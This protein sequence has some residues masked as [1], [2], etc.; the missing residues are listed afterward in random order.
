MWRGGCYNCG[1]AYETLSDVCDHLWSEGHNLQMGYTGL[2]GY[3][4]QYYSEWA[5]CNLIEARVPITVE[6]F[7]AE[8]AR[9]KKD[10]ALTSVADD[11]CAI[12]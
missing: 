5:F 6:N 4:E 11:G 12:A 10:R 7:D 2:V 1:F 3:S 8:L 9:F